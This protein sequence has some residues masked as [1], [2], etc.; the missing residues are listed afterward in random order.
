MSSDKVFRPDREDV[1]GNVGEEKPR[2]DVKVLLFPDDLTLGLLMLLDFDFDD[3]ATVDDV[4]NDM[5]RLVGDGSV[6]TMVAL[7]TRDANGN[8]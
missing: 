6:S 8:M 2:G 4:E 1:L 3:G 5:P 7:S